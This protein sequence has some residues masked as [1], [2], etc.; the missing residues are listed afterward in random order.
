VKNSSCNVT[1]RKIA[2]HWQEVPGNLSLVVLPPLDLALL[3]REEHWAKVGEREHGR[4]CGRR[5]RRVAFLADRAS[6]G[7]R[8]F[9][10]EMHRA[11]LQNG[12]AAR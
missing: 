12:D 6:L 4:H 10:S 8:I 1:Q 11:P 2:P 3:K 7:R 9:P 5:R